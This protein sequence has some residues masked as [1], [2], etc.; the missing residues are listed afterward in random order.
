MNDFYVQY[1]ILQ[2]DDGRWGHPD[3]PGRGLHHQLPR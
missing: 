2:L 3:M 1:R